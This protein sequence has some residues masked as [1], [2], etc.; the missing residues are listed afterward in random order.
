MSVKHTARH[1]G[2]AWYMVQEF[3]GAKRAERTGLPLINH[4]E[5][6]VKVLVELNASPEVIDAFIIHP[7]YQTLDN[8]DDTLLVKGNSRHLHP[9]AIEFAKAYKETANSYLCKPHYRGPEDEIRLSEFWQ[10]NL[11]LVADKVQNR[12]DFELHYEHQEDKEVFNR[13]EEL[14]QYFKN[15]LKALGVP[16][17]V[18]FKLKEMIS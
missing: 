15:W 12:K 6:G 2:Y 8:P 11:M 5:E 18:Y 9:K 4:I 10:V 17:S 16:E 3:Y 7:V 1:R 13:T 14:A